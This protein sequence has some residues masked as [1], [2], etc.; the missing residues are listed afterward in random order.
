MVLYTGLTLIFNYNV[1]C[2]YIR[3]QTRE[4][5]ARYQSGYHLYQGTF[6]SPLCVKCA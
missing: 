2:Y 4:V 5:H 6:I 1:I 3:M